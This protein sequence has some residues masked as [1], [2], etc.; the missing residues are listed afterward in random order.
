LNFKHLQK[1][2]E[3]INN[4]SEEESTPEIFKQMLKERILK[5][6][7]NDVKNDVR[8][9]LRNP[10]ELNIWSTDYFLQL[11]DMMKVLSI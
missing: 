3:Q 1:R 5:T 10:Q 9:F 4:L 11:A 7:I 2:A 6:N 8:P